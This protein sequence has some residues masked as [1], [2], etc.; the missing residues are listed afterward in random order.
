MPKK[1][2][3]LIKPSHTLTSCTW[4]YPP[5]DRILVNDTFFA[6]LGKHHI[7]YHC[8][9]ECKWMH[10]HQKHI[11]SNHLVIRVHSSKWKVNL[12]KVADLLW[13]H[14]QHCL[15]QHDRLDYNIHIKLCSVTGLLLGSIA[16]MMD[17]LQLWCIAWKVWLTTFCYMSIWKK[18]KPYD[19][20]PKLINL[21]MLWLG[22]K[23]SGTLMTSIH[24]ESA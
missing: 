10:P 17:C 3:Y 16:F 12:S 15:L 11:N 6:S 23:G 2:I 5:R 7:L 22:Q 18:N 4:E 24:K 21:D 9:L 13:L 20:S 1:G 14:W 8:V 19:V